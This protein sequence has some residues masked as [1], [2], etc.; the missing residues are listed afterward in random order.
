MAARPNARLDKLFQAP[1][2]LPTAARRAASVLWGKIWLSQ[3]SVHAASLSHSSEI[4]RI[5]AE[6]AGSRQDVSVRPGAGRSVNP[7][8]VTLCRPP[9][10]TTVCAHTDTHGHIDICTHAHTHTCG[11]LHRPAHICMHIHPH[12][13]THI[14]MQRAAP[15]G[16]HMHAY[17]P[18]HMHTCTH[19]H[20]ESCTHRHTH[21]QHPQTHVHT[22]ADLHPQALTCI[23]T[24]SD[25]CTCACIHTCRQLHPQAH[26]HTHKH[27]GVISGASFGSR[28]KVN[29]MLCKLLSF[30]PGFKGP[31]KEA[32]TLHSAPCFYGGGGPLV[33]LTCFAQTEP[34][35]HCHP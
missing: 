6:H 34:R 30:G 12:T 28:I 14:H 10:P 9:C 26:I 5:P 16:T 15:T 20:V 1:P 24:H 32:S 8:K 7:L 4:A 22:G 13:C 35:A 27:T 18:T 19:T 23:R 33:W 25:S 3:Q 11:E 2:P 17:T 31:R 29:S 21:A